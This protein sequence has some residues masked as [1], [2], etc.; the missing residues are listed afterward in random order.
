MPGKSVKNWD[1]YHALRRKGHDKESAARIA[2]TDNHAYST[3]KASFAGYGVLDLGR[4][5]SSVDG[6]QDDGAANISARYH[7]N[8]HSHMEPY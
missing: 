5:T 6:I 7:L 4:F 2:N 1:A 8:D 3:P